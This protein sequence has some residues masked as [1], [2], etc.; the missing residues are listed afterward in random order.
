MR[1]FILR[2]KVDG[3]KSIDKEIEL[4]F[5]NST[6]KKQLFTSNSHVKA[7]YGPNGAGKTGIILAAEIYWNLVL[8]TKYVAVNNVNGSF[9]NLINQKTKRFKVCIVFA[10]L[11]DEDEVQAVYE[12]YFVLAFQNGEFRIAEEKLSI[13]SGNNIN[14]TEKYN[15]VYHTVNGVL[16][17]IFDGCQY[18]ETLKLSTMNL[19]SNSCFIT[20]FVFA[21]PEL[22][23]EEIDINLVKH[24]KNVIYFV[25][26][27]RVVLQDSDTD[28]IDFLRIERQLN[29]LED[30]KKRTQDESM[31]SEMLYGKKIHNSKSK[32]ISKDK[33]PVYQER[34]KNLCRF[35]KVFKDDLVDIEIKKEENGDFY[36][37][38]NI[39]V[40][41]DKRINENYESTGI[42]KI[43][44]IYA[45]LCDLNS[46]KI[47]F[48]D[49]F[50]ANVHDVLLL[51][52]IEYAMTYAKGQLIFTT[53]N[54]GP[55]DVLKDG[56]NSID[57]LSSD[58]RLV[59]WIKNGHY[60]PASQYKGGYI[61]YS[62]FNIEP[63]N[64][65]GVFGGGEK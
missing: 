1:Y 65:L 25:K 42:K 30:Q 63:F 29:L 21:N 17:E 46:G 54:L 53:H 9:I 4:N 11:N 8:G 26:D 13:L 12:H 61:Q 50:D 31:F 45:A 24:F 49:E 39:L 60:S 32:H 2:M 16:E 35:I 22:K 51:K 6:F 58:S 64:F 23:N 28:Y 43:I 36:E 20:A 44:E 40:Y 33:F 48:I 47:V 27:I 14:I 3:I 10:C 38:E 41:E 18:V 52:I 19:L 15:T 55:M 37:C 34:I 57:F 56:K 59:S 5:Y 7:I 62:P